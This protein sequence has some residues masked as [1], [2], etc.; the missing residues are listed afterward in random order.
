MLYNSIQPGNIWLDT[1]GNP[2]QAHGGSIYTEDGTFYW[3][4]ENKEKTTSDNDIWHWGVRCYSSNDLYN[5]IDLGLIIPPNLEDK[6]S[7]LHPTKCMDRPHIIYNRKTKKYA[8]WIKIIEDFGIQTMTVLQA[9]HFLGPYELAKLRLQPCGMYS[10]DF[11]LFVERRDGKGYI[12]FDRPHTDVVCAN[13]TEDYLDVSG[14]YSTH[15]PHMGTPFARE[16]PAHFERHGKHFLFTS[17][18]S[19]YFPNPSE[20]AQA[21]SIHG[22]WITLGNAHSDDITNT[23]F[24]SQISSVFKHPYKKDLYIAVADRWIPNIEE[25]LGDHYQDGSHWIQKTQ[26]AQML[27]EGKIDSNIDM[28]HMSSKKRTL[29]EAMSQNTSIARYVWL[30]VQFTEDGIPYIEWANEWRVEDYE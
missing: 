5:W 2:I 10:G 26:E 7:P 11:D 29:K 4:G 12:L 18:T 1:N 22:P 24:N 20:I 19:G 23:S 28:K 27:I 8:C 9:D 13:L 16:A 14:Y 3:Y 21:L 15:L 17:G 30:P 6:D 25:L